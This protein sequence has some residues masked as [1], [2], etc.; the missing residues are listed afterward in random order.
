[1]FLV[2]LKRYNDGKHMHKVIT[3][4]LNVRLASGFTL[5]EIMVTMIIIGILSGVSIVGYGSW[6][7]STITA[8][9]KSDLNGAVAA[10]DNARNF[11]NGYPTAIPTTFKPSNGVTLSGGGVLGGKGYC[12]TATNEKWRNSITQDKVILSGPCPVFSIDAGNKLSYPGSGVVITDLSGNNN[13]GDLENGVSYSSS[14]GGILVFDSPG[15]VINIPDS[16]T[17][18][19]ATE[20]SIEAWLRPTAEYVGYASHPITKWS[21]TTDANF[22]L[23]YF[24]TTSGMSRNLILYANAGGTWRGVAPS[25]QATLNQW[26]YI[27]Y[28]YSSA[29]GGKAY[30]NGSLIGSID[31]GGLLATNN[32]EMTIGESFTGQVGFVRLYNKLFSADDVKRNFEASR[33]RYGL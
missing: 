14:N 20:V 25:Y 17:L 2:I 28:T 6:K 4:K 1:L 29:S 7:E 24:G 8:Q 18:D 15:K 33:S 19:L 26:V 3:K 9:L 13:N 23:Y 31:S 10:M 30:A 5:V 22:T 12:I 11:G 21:G 32:T 27:V 16:N